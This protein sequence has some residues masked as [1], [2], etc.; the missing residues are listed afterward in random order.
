MTATPTATVE[1]AQFI[2]RRLREIEEQLK[3]YE[4]LERE[5]R[6]LQQALGA[7]RAEEPPA[8][9]RSRA[10]RGSNLA[11][12][13]AYVAETPGSTAAEIAEATGISRSV[14][15]SATSRLA[16]G[17]RLRREAKPDGSVAY[18]PADA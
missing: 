12:I 6:R 7:L 13:L 15:Y 11:A 18:H 17:G 4:E 10:A 2:E 14:I 16:S 5:Q 9:T 3:P 8:P 1:V